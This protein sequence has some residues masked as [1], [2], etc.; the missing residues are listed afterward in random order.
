MTLFNY[1]SSQIA[2]VRKQNLSKLWPQIIGGTA[3]VVFVFLSGVLSGSERLLP[4][5]MAASLK[6]SFQQVLTELPNYL[7]NVPVHFLHERRYEGSGVTVNH[8]GTDDQLI[9]IGAFMDGSNEFRLVRRDGQIIN[10]W[11]FQFYDIYPNPEHLEFPPATNWNINT[12]G[13]V[14]NADGSLVFNFAGM[15]LVKMN[16]C[17]VVTWALAAQTH[18]SVER[19]E[20]GGY[21][22]PNRRL[23][24]TTTTS[25]Y[26]FVDAPY[27]V[28]TILHVSEDGVVMAEISIPELL[29]QNGL[30]PVLTAVENQVVM[31]D[32]FG[33]PEII[34][35]NDVEALPT[36][37]ADQFPLFEAGD[38][39]LSIR[40][41]NMVFVFD[42]DTEKIKWHQTGPWIHQHDP[43]FLD[44][45]ILSLFNN[46]PFKDWRAPGE[47][48]SAIS[49]YNFATGQSRNIFG[50]E[51]QNPF[52]S[53]IRGMHQRLDNGGIL[54]TEADSGRLFQIN[55][56]G[57]LVWEFING[58]DETRVAEIT[59]GQAYPVD[60]FDV[61]DWSCPQ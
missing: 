9:M 51:P 36:S 43:D 49:E 31:G 56:Q 12:Q 30:G 17:G 1:I 38:L 7:Q 6:D 54:I 27:F 58:Y 8:H 42:P 57:E 28:D 4:Y 25:S 14:L 41:Y 20:T 21:W 24:D 37:M 26:P 50:D 15:G 61:E 44:D 47:L 60:Y 3:V 53:A 16:R 11:R 10:Q 39:M 13:F 59:G 19:N 45:G 48:H 5:Q 2:R 32:R 33:I 18:H 52:Y 34:H 22:V 35:L 23:I 29:T 40:G 46:R 55:A